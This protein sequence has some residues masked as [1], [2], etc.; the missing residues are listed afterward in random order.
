MIKSFTQV[1]TLLLMDSM[2]VNLIFISG[3]VMSTWL[4]LERCFW[5]NLALMSQPKTKYH[6]RILKVLC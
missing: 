3:R 4:S 2:T 5:V 6:R 1:Q